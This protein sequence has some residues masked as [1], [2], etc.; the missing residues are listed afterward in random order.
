MDFRELARKESSEFIDRVAAAAEELARKALAQAT[1]ET[2]KARKQLQKVEAQLQAET[3]RAAVLEADLDSTIE[4]HR[5]VDSA[6]ATAEEALAEAVAAH[7]ESM[8]AHADAM[9]ANARLHDDLA[10]ARVLL[11]RARTEATRVTEALEAEIA[12]KA[13][14]QE[15]AA[16]ARELVE[17]ERTRFTADITSLHEQLEA[18]AAEAERMRNE[19]T[20]ARGD[21][22]ALR[23][24]LETARGDADMLRADLDIARAD[25]DMLRAE[26]SAAQSEIEALR[27]ERHTAQAQLETMGAE[28][29]SARR[30]SL[31][32]HTEA[33]GYRNEL[34]AARVEVNA[35]RTEAEALR[36]RAEATRADVDAIRAEAE[37]LRVQRAVA[38]K[39]VEVVRAERTHAQAEIESLRTERTRALAEIDALRAGRTNVDAEAETIRAARD[40]ALAEVDALRA[41]R[42]NLVAESESVR[43]ELARTRLAV[44][45]AEESA[46]A[47]VGASVRSVRALGSTKTLE[48]L[49]ATLVDEMRPLLPRVVLF[50]V[51]GHHLEGELG[52]GLDD[53]IDITKLSLPVSLDSLVTRA[54]AAGTLICADHTQIES[55][56]PPIGGS[57]VSAVAAPLT[58]GGESFA[59]LYGD[60]TSP[61]SDAQIAAIELLTRNATL[62]LS[63]LGQEVRMLTEM[64]EYASMLIAEAEQMFNADLDAG[65]PADERVRRLQT[66]IECARQLYS[67]RAELEG[68]G[69]AGL[70]DQQL[71][72]V[73]SQ[74]TPF[75]EALG[76]AVQSA[77]R[78]RTA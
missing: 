75:G 50:R 77:D 58:F 56:P 59:V 10:S 42:T 49:F 17:R 11:E 52:A 60:S 78:V 64:R 7:A 45:R 76:A 29:E 1:Q 23:G 57:A 63:R 34:E 33:A 15:D 48:G 8:A 5:Q 71:A 31:E 37:A 36:L 41:E 73:V 12:Q 22:D 38:Q 66:S 51:K 14:A 39:E 40:A 61:M 26:R 72:S 32:A 25:A 55:T 65:R 30:A 2:E 54:M 3:A 20:A 46:A 9:A 69:A 18:A 13:L 24:D 43:A 47:L 67:Q 19:L 27:S 4:A 16:S 21:A 70:L 6:R 35:L 62:I 68:I 74:R 28:L 53:S 44:H